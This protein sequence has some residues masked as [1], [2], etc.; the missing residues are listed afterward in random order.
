MFGPHDGWGLYPCFAFFIETVYVS[1]AMKH[2]PFSN[3]AVS[4]SRL[5]TRSGFPATLCG[6]RC[7]GLVLLLCLSVAP[8]SQVWAKQT[9]AAKEDV[10]PGKLP[11]SSRK[12]GHDETQG[13]VLSIDSATSDVGKS[14]AK[15]KTGATVIETEKKASA[16]KAKK[17][18]PAAEKKKEKKKPKESKPPRKKADRKSE[19][20]AQKPQAEK[21]EVTAMPAAENWEAALDEANKALK[22]NPAD[23]AAWMAKIRALDGMGTDEALDK[24]DD[25]AEKKPDVPA[26]HAARARILERQLDTLEA[27]DAWNRAIA[28]DPKNDEYRLR[29]AQLNEQMGR[30]AD[31]IK[32]YKSVKSLPASAQKRLEALSRL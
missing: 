27:V 5:I 21:K 26:V 19:E 13:I 17:A 9:S 1:R 22:K 3:P 2:M 30:K 16:P 15:G 31:A 8:V 29:L 14:S 28:L 25:M 4:G 24:L 23:K 6:V 10:K 7:L 12:T 18:A 32:A 11:K 20:K